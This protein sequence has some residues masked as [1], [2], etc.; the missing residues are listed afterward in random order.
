MAHL[1]VLQR[2]DAPGI[3]K[4]G[5]SDDPVRRA[6][7]LEASHCF[8]VTVAARMDHQGSWE[9]AVHAALDDRRVQGGAGVEWFYCSVAEAVSA[10]ERVVHQQHRFAAQALARRRARQCLAKAA[11]LERQA[12]AQCETQ[13]GPE[14][15][16]CGRR[17]EERQQEA[18]CRHKRALMTA[19][20]RGGR[21]RKA[22]YLSRSTGLV[23]GKLKRKMSGLQ[24]NRAH[25][26]ARCLAYA[27]EAEIATRRA[28][29]ET[30]FPTCIG[31][32]ARDPYKAQR[33][34]SLK[35]E[36]DRAYQRLR[37][38]R[39]TQQ[40]QLCVALAVARLMREAWGVLLA[41]P[42]PLRGEGPVIALGL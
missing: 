42:P 10:I 33:L 14:L 3:V 17:A 7:T 39:R 15:A 5:R 8:R 25:E 18:W 11:V 34:E 31:L 1:Y 30:K 9:H 38:V 24:G 29:R 2:S 32:A 19:S 16:E 13:Q 36:Y 41:Q 6:S 37:Y 4:I 35:S 12:N 28:T 20:A 21:M 40:P 27:A 26:I 22:V 23:F